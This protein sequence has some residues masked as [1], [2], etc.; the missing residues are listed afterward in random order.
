MWVDGLGL[1]CIFFRSFASALQFM[2]SYPIST[3][4]FTPFCSL[5]QVSFAVSL[6]MIEVRM[7]DTL[8]GT[9]QTCRSSLVGRRPKVER[10][11]LSLSFAVRLVL[12]KICF[13]MLHHPWLPNGRIND[14]A[15]IHETTLGGMEGIFKNSLTMGKGTRYVWTGKIWDV[16]YQNF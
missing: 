3:V 4:L 9:G 10:C 15:H 13:M 14:C 12:L 16:V 6:E 5:R 7:S 2:V 1:P 11:T 8:R